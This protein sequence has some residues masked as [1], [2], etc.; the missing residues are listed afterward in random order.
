M[1]WHLDTRTL[2][3]LIAVADAPTAAQAAG[4]L[5]VTPSA[6]SHQMRKAEASLRVALFDRRGRRAR[7]T[8]VGE[9][10][11]AAARAIVAGLEAAEGVLERSR[12]G[13][14][15]AVRVG[16]GPYPVQRL[17]L[18]RLA[19]EDLGQIDWVARTSFPLAQAVAEGEVDLALAP[20]RTSQRGVTAEP[21]FEDDLVAVVPE[22]HP[23]ARAGALD[24]AG[25]ASET[26]VTYSRVI[27]EGMEDE[28][29]FRPAR[30]APARV[31]LAEGVEA[32]LDVVASG[33]G[34]SILSR[35]SV[36]RPGLAAIPLTAAGTR[37]RWSLLRREAERDAEVLALGARVAGALRT[38]GG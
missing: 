37:V 7:L 24:R 31:A 8:P 4:R 2:R 35:W 34:F 15:R 10:L 5:A 33:G 22:G 26:Y 25:Y 38:L 9:Q 14:R 1:A 11:L 23:M 13:D 12:R 16:G 6:L 20:S 29:V 21:L 3:M 27:E 18:P 36:G 19:P 30:A 17:L 32:I 28:T